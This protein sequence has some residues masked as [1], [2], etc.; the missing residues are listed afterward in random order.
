[1]IPISM[2][3]LEILTAMKAQSF[4]HRYL[5][6]EF[7]KRQPHQSPVTLNSYS[8]YINQFIPSCIS[9]GIL[10]KE[11]HFNKVL[12]VFILQ[13]TIDESRFIIELQPEFEDLNDDFRIH[14]LI[15]FADKVVMNTAELMV[16]TSQAEQLRMILEQRITESNY[17]ELRIV[18]QEIKEKCMMFH[19]ENIAID[20]VLKNAGLL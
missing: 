13:T 6:D 18:Y 4:D 11:V 9:G 17:S 16:R 15:A 20:T 5:V 1:M 2:C 3:F 19:G 8:R 14:E 7:E 12:P 10:R